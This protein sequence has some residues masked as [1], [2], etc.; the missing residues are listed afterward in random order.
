VVRVHPAFLD[1]QRL[2][3]GPP[4]NGGLRPPGGDLRRDQSFWDARFE[5][6]NAE[7]RHLVRNG[8]VIL[9]FFLNVSKA[10]QKKRFMDRL[11]DPT[12]NWKFSAGDVKER[13]HW[14]EYMAAF[15]DMLSAT[16]TEWAPW[17]AIPADDKWA[18]R[19]LVADVMVSAIQGLNLS[20]PVV[21]EAARKANEEARRLLESE[22][23][24]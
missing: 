15:S 16:S 5:D 18:A 4:P 22:G 9:K 2:P 21:S 8:T 20:Y 1:A 19:T 17:Y 10:E 11:E 7:E 14:D 6:I 12:K 23:K 3:A 13:Q 24:S